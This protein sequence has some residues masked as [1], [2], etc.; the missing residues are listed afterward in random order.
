MCLQPYGI[1]HRHAVEA[2]CQRLCRNFYRNGPTSSLGI[3]E[4][5]FDNKDATNFGRSR[6]RRSD[7]I[8]LDISAKPSNI[9]HPE[10]VLMTP[11]TNLDNIRSEHSLS[12]YPINGKERTLILT[13]KGHVGF[14]ENVQVGDHITVLHGCVRERPFLLR[15]L[16][17]R[18][19]HFELVHQSYLW[20]ATGQYTDWWAEEDAHEIILV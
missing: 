17:G 13:A 6:T 2:E 15:P 11:R 19:Q 10:S 3:G 8:L 18:P 16:Q 7:R 12:V 4:N 9:F 20:I 1:P 5:S 14:A